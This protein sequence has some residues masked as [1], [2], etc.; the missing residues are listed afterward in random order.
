MGQA[1][2]VA[3]ILGGSRVLGRKVCEAEGLINAIRTGVPYKAFDAAREAAGLSREEACAIF[4]IPPRTLARRKKE[5]RLTVEESDRVYRFAFLIAKAQEVL[6]ER[7]KTIR[8]L[9]KPNRALGNAAPI[10]RLDTDLGTR[11]VEAILG[12]LEYGVFS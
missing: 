5:G 2:S 9:R 4:G 6:G 12:R 10:S 1:L 8:W 11:Q 3:E 7:Q